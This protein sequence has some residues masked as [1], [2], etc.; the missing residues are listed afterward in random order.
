[1]SMEMAGAEA[2][3]V[4]DREACMSHHDVPALLMALGEDGIVLGDPLEHVSEEARGGH[5]S[6]HQLGTEPGK[7]GS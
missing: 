7:K 4:E 3:A 1:M 2:L 5:G 6:H